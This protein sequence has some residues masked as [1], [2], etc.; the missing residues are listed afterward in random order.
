MGLDAMRSCWASKQ[1]VATEM[2]NEALIPK[3]VRKA[4]T[5]LDKKNP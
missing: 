2:K 4:G 3:E 1:H 5:D